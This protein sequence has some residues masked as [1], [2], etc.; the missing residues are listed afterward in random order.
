MRLLEQFEHYLFSEL[1]ILS[2]VYLPATVAVHGAS[3][4]HIDFVIPRG[5]NAASILHR[6][7]H[8]RRSVSLA[9]LRRA[10]GTGATDL[11]LYL[12]ELCCWTRSFHPSRGWWS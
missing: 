3:V 2:S 10:I 8:T 9:L 12:R 11:P 6:E 5:I 7:E 4:H 1:K